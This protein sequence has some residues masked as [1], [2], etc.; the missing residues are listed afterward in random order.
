MLFDQLRGA[1]MHIHKANVGYEGEFVAEYGPN[2]NRAVLRIEVPAMDM[3][4]AFRRLNFLANQCEQA[5]SGGHH[6]GVSA[7][8][9]IVDLLSKWDS[10]AVPGERYYTWLSAATV[11]NPLPVIVSY[12]QVEGEGEE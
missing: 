3:G 8:M 10:S 2:E 12:E 7:Y 1:H 5:L 4:V 6:R 9:K 11:E